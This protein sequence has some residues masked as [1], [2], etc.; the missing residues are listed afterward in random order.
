MGTPTC[1]IIICTK[2]RERDLQRCLDSIAKQIRPPEEL[3]VVDSGAD[4]T[5]KRV[6][7]F[8]ATFNGV[9]CYLHTEP[10]LTLQR[11]A[12]IRHATGDIVH[13]ID[14]DTVLEPD[15]IKVIQETYDAPETRDAVAVA[16]RVA[17][18][19][20]PGRLNTL[21]RR[22]FLLARQNGTGRIL[23]SGFGSYTWYARCTDLH[24]V[25]VISGCCQSYRRHVFDHL[26]YDEFFQGYGYMEDVDFSYRVG[27]L[28]RMVC[29]PA[30]RMAH[31]ET[32][33]TRTPQRRLVKMQVVNH[34][35]V[36]KKN[37]PH[38]LFHWACFWWSDLGVCLA[39]LAKGL[40]N[41]NPDILLGLAEG[42]LAILRGIPVPTEGGR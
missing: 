32:P 20:T 10:G 27:R 9:V 33:N 37:L 22:F 34:F 17:T 24:P 40:I 18:P 23:P 13:L 26:R 2:D 1:T 36:F 41:L 35:Y 7:T 29:N 8:R 5:P 11:N 15:Y 28:G 16:P 38:D 3:V 12:G 42:H 14:D 31:L 30:A 21:Y 19:R 25:E 4:E 39:R 6:E